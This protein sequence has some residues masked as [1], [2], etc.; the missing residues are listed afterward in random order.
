MTEETNSLKL[1]NY[2]KKLPYWYV[3]GV[4]Q[5]S[6]YTSFQIEKLC[7][8]YSLCPE[9]IPTHQQYRDLINNERKKEMEKIKS[10]KPHVV[11]DSNKNK[12]SFP[13]WYE[14]IMNENPELFEKIK[15]MDSEW[16]HY[17]HSYNTL[18][19]FYIGMITR[20]WEYKMSFNRTR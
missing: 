11:M 5:Y 9:D 18:Y 15:E 12:S 1:S 19:D 16:S 17:I 6:D 13:L 3:S 8:L 2:N 14:I 4:L 20:E 10:Y 7:K